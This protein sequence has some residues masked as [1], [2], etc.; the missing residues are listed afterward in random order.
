MKTIEI[1]L[2]W[3]FSLL[4]LGLLLKIIIE[5]I[6]LKKFINNINKIYPIDKIDNKVEVKY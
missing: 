4:F 1:L 3:F 2:I 5:Y 6:I